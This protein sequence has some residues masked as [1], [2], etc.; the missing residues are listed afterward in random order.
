[1][2]SAI[3]AY[4]LRQLSDIPYGL[5]YFGKLVSSSISFSMHGR[6]ARKILIMQLLFTFIE[7]LPITAILA[8]GLGTAIF[9][10]GYPFL[11]SLGRSSLIYSL[12]IMVMC[13]ELGPLLIAFVVTAR[14][15]TAIATEIGGMVIHH[16][17]EAYISV[18][19]DPIDHLA[20]PRF[21]GVMASLF[22]LNLYF[23]FFGVL[24]PAIVIQFINPVPFSEYFA[25]VFRELSIVTIGISLLKSMFFGMAIATVSTFYG[26]AVEQASTEVPVAGI[27]AVGKSILYIVLIDVFITVLVYVF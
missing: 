15:A 11:L 9:L 18:G 6:T 13:Q 25:G 14:S 26:F 4:V 20:A 22:F 23:S 16:E 2:V 12:L 1:M 17:I 8:V 5:G 19:V 10:V 7:A 24:A 3:G 21:I 27:K